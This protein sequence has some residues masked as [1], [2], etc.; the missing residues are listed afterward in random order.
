MRSESSGFR[1]VFVQKFVPHYRL[2][3]F[4]RFRD[5]LAERG[6]ELV[7]VYGPPDPFEGSKVRTE[8]PAW[9]V[10]T[11]TR[12][13]RVRGRWLYRQNAGRHV[14]PGDLVIVE[15]AAKLLDNYGLYLASRRGRIGFGYFGHG[16][17]FLVDGELR[18]SS[19]VKRAM[20]GNVTRWFAYTEVSRA[21]LVAQGVDDELVTVVNN[22]LPAPASRLEDEPVRESSFLYIGGL[23]ADKRLD[24]LLEAATVVAASHPAFELHVV[25]DG[26]L[27]SMLDEAASSRSWLRVHGPLYGVERDR[28]L[29][30]SAAILM[31]GA[32][33][34][35]AIDSLHF[36]CPVLTTDSR[37]HGPEIAYL[38]HDVN[39][40]FA[41]AP[42]GVDGFVAVLRGFVEEPGLAA[43]LRAACA[44]SAERYTMEDMVARFVAGVERARD[45]LAGR[46]R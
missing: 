24:V 22:T 26:P 32:V 13:F 14:R 29:A 7:L 12:F 1:V 25:G 39:A 35:V 36:R 44:A 9:G 17:N 37:A 42:V 40:L 43:R 34:L 2:P 6:I 5:A 30:R 19:R 16:E 28:M 41:E 21:S 46:R 27:R 31:P 8:S 4:E 15:H 3:F 11:D 45:D 33:G 10:R 18:V 20:L 23:Y 38:E